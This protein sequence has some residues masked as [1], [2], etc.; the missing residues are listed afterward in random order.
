[1]VCGDAATG[2]ETSA[3]AVAVAY[4]HTER[5]P[6]SP[7]PAPARRPPSASP[8]PPRWPWS[9]P[10]PWRRPSPYACSHTAPC[11]PQIERMSAELASAAAEANRWREAAEALELSQQMMA[12]VVLVEKA[13]DAGSVGNSQLYARVQQSGSAAAAATASTAHAIRAAVPAWV[14]E[15]G[16]DGQADGRTW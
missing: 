15:W 16:A 11:T 1:M 6:P 9:H 8:C 14:P 7:S 5:T 2:D 3:A 10:S 12:D 4:L 13:A